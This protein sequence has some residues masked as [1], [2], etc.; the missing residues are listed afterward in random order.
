M[1]IN[2]D[3]ISIIDGNFSVDRLMKLKEIANHE[4]MILTD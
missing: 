4:K 1:N 3:K 2:F